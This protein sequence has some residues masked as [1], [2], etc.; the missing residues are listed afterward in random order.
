MYN[1]NQLNRT[2]WLLSIPFKYVFSFENENVEKQNRIPNNNSAL[3]FLPSLGGISLVNLWPFESNW[4]LLQTSVKSFLY[5]S[6]LILEENRC[7]IV[8][9]CLITLHSPYQNTITFCQEIAVITEREINETIKNLYLFTTKQNST[10]VQSL[11]N[12]I[13]ELLVSQKNQISKI[14]YICLMLY[15]CIHHHTNVCSI[16]GFM[17]SPTI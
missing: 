4:Q 13:P 7:Q 9:M 16:L 12:K 15:N 2:E 5:S 3:S 17:I 1:C 11:C 8:A 6:T 10:Q 14:T